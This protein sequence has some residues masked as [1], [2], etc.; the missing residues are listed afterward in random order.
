MGTPW[1]KLRTAQYRARHPQVDRRES[2]RLAQARYRK[3]HAKALAEARFVANF[4][5]RRA[6]YH[7]DIER[8]AAA[9]RSRLTRAG[10]AALRAE[11]GRK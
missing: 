2:R 5:M 8:L 9:L 7:G 6:E 3:R 1:S 4:L 11:L 10:I